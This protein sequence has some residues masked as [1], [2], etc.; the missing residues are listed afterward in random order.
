MSQFQGFGIVPYRGTHGKT[1]PRS[2]ADC[3]EMLTLA[4]KRGRN[5]KRLAGNTYLEER[6]GGAFAVRLHSTDIVTF[7]ADGSARL[8]S[9]AW[10]TPTT[11]E[12]MRA[13]GFPVY[14]AGG[15]AEVYGRAFLDGV[16]IRK[17]R[18]LR[19]TD[20]G[21]AEEVRILRRR[22]L[23]KDPDAWRW[24][25]RQGG[26]AYLGNCPQAHPKKLR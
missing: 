12:R 26:R 16:V 19:K 4:H 15:V 10:Q 18:T 5:N 23:R 24:D 22:E 8:N 2:Y 17:G 21:D 14:L 3:K 7:L 6:E 25:M 11:R 13:C 9:G 1:F 20:G